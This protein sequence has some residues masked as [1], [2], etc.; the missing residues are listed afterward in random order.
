VAA[1]G[2]GRGDKRD[3]RIGRREEAEAIYHEL[4]RKH[5]SSRIWLRRS[6][7]EWEEEG[8]TRQHEL[9][10]KRRRKRKSRNYHG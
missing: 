7:R 3:S 6:D 10:R 9:E 5:S 8:V 4:E 2:G 1:T